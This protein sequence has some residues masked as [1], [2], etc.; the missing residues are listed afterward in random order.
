MIYTLTSPFTWSES[1]SICRLDVTCCPSAPRMQHAISLPYPFPCQ[2]ARTL[3]LPQIVPFNVYE[4][5][6]HP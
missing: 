1:S 4:R 5:C 3:Q 6:Q 2:L